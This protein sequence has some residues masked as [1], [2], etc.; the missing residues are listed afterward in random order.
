MRRNAGFIY[1]S[2]LGRRALAPVR[3]AYDVEGNVGFPKSE[4]KMGIERS[5]GRLVSGLTLLALAGCGVGASAD[6]KAAPA[7]ADRAAYLTPPEATEVR[8][9]PGGA[10]VVL[11]RAEPEARV[12]AVTPG[13]GRAFGATADARGRFSLMI[14]GGAEAALVV[15]SAEGERRSTQ[16]EGYLF[17]PIDAPA[18]AV[19]LR[20]GAPARPLGPMLRPLAAVD[21]DPA[22]GAAVSGRVTPNATVTVSVDGGVPV[23]TKADASGVYGVRLASA[24]LA[25]G[26]HNFRVA[27]GGLVADRSLVLAPPPSDQAGAAREP[28]AWRV[29]W[30]APGGG[31]QATLVVAAEP[32]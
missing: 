3:Q 31:R 6:G 22:G 14:P 29:N 1:S 9:S 19:L 7:K 23:Q 5:V 8:T 28:G 17:I 13:T 16:A 25:P 18:G 20:P 27:S 32:S 30:P 15:L 4:G 12:R 26:L 24:R 21:Y 2:G 10:T 11:G